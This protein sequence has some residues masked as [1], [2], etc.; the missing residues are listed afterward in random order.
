MSSGCTRRDYNPCATAAPGGTSIQFVKQQLWLIP[1]LLTAAL[2]AAYNDYASAKQ[3]IDS[4]EGGRLRAG[5]RVTLTYRELAA[6]VEHEAPAGVRSPQ[7]RVTSPEI[8]TGTA[9]VDF[10]KVR[11]SQG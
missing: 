2:G 4:I 9:L 8:A 11:R 7:I 6:W 3:K 10:G 1:V 5:S